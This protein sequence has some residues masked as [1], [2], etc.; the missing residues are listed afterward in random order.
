MKSFSAVKL[1]VFVNFVLKLFNSTSLMPLVCAD[2]LGL[3]EGVAAD[4]FFDVGFGCAGFEFG[5]DVEGV[6]F[7]EVSVCS[8]GGA[9]AAVADFAEVVCALFCAVGEGAVGGDAF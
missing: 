6:E 9:G 5:H 2:E 7:E 4:E 8:A 1:R 3:V